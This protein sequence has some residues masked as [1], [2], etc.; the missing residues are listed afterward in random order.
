MVKTINGENYREAVPGV[1]SILNLY[2]FETRPTSLDID[3]GQPAYSGKVT[4]MLAT[5]SVTEGMPPANAAVLNLG[6]DN[7][8]WGAQLA[9]GNGTGALFGRGFNAN[10]NVMSWG[11]WREYISDFNI[12][13]FLQISG[14][15]YLAQTIPATNGLPFAGIPHGTGITDFAGWMKTARSG[16]YNTLIGSDWYNVYLL[17]YENG[18]SE[19]GK[20][21]GMYI[22]SKTMEDDYLRWN[23][24]IDGKTGNTRFIVDHLNYK[25][26]IFNHGT[27]TKTTQFE[28]PPDGS[29]IAMQQYNPDTDT[30][31][32]FQ[33][34][35]S[36][37]V[38]IYTKTGNGGWVNG[39]ID[40]AH[41]ENHFLPLAGGTMAGN[42]V[43]KNVTLHDGVH[44]R[45][46][47]KVFD[48]GDGAND[49][50]SELTL[51][52]GGNTFIGSGESADNLRVALQ[53]AL[54]EGEIYGR[55]GEHLYLSADSNLCLYSNCNE[56]GKRK[57]IVFNTDGVLMPIGASSIKLGAYSNRLDAGYIKDG[58]ITNFYASYIRYNTT[59][60]TGFNMFSDYVMLQRFNDSS[61][62]AILLECSNT[63]NYSISPIIRPVRNGSGTIGTSSYKWNQ[64]WA[65]NGAI[66][67]S[68]KNEK[69]EI[70]YYGQHS[71]YDTYI[72][73]ETLKSFIRGLLS[74]IYK[75]VNGE[76][77]RP[78]HGFIAQDVE[79]LL[80][81]LGIKDHA[82]FIKS[83]KTETVEIEEEAEET[84]TDETDGQTRTRT[85]IQK[86]EEQREIP[87]EYI[88]G[89]RYEEFIADIVRFV[90]L[91][92]ERIEEQEKIIYEQQKELDNQRE[93]INALKARLERLEALLLY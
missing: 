28:Y 16:F 20:K 58:Y 8:K 12:N 52:G 66:Q 63:S 32:R 43:M 3:L 14:P 19:D 27:I 84:Y 80:Q 4:Y 65:T 87:G 15:T 5:G 68:D 88:Y 36:G 33:I 40:F 23:K 11:K 24:M 86:R 29:H 93:E 90:Q 10:I 6:W 18:Y 81:K 42:I 89:L 48:D 57:G 50:G 67:T 30:T 76:S 60:N 79:E 78:H 70:S 49:Y 35:K 55:L 47:M 34:S 61:N 69:K 41:L 71:N 56:A 38:R 53:T 26:L 62:N 83:P 13:A 91:Q 44:A 17:K 21:Y 9:I 74:V 77:D 51:S 39:E 92:D 37:T 46:V 73:D 59:S 45:T 1:G 82:G 22:S 31:I 64:V 54:L 85:V 25:E 7:S 72:D 2:G 75:R